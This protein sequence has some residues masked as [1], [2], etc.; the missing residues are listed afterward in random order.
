VLCTMD[1]CWFRLQVALWENSLFSKSMY[2][3]ISFIRLIEFKR[4]KEIKLYAFTHSFIQTLIFFPRQGIILVLE[5]TTGK[6]NRSLCSWNAQY[7]VLVMQ[8]TLIIYC[9]SFLYLL[10]K[11]FIRVAMDIFFIINSMYPY[12][13]SPVWP[14]VLGNIVGKLREILSLS[15][16]LQC[17][18]M[19]WIINF[20]TTQQYCWILILLLASW[21]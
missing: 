13:I 18:A 7:S 9:N 15:T 12:R 21:V 19:I 1:N 2:S 11:A 17:L 8:N 6:K 20:N 5:K 10:Q 16:L 14:H 3:F 4:E